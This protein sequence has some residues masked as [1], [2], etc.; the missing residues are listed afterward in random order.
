[1][2]R[3][4][5]MSV[6][7]LLSASVVAAAMFA[8][9]AAFADV[10][11]VGGVGVPTGS[12]VIAE[13]GYE[14]DASAGAFMGIGI[15]TQISDGFANITYGIGGTNPPPYLYSEFSGFTFQQQVGTDFF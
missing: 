15:V 3:E 4:F 7:S 2:N 12:V 5:F 11:N 1:M 13:N 9:S 14:A 10:V 8:S 6:K